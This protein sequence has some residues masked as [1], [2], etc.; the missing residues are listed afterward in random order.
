MDYAREQTDVRSL[1]SAPLG[2]P[3]R[4]GWTPLAHTVCTLLLISLSAVPLQAQERVDRVRGVVFDSLANEVLANA[5]VV[6]SPGGATA[7][8]DSL[9]RFELISDVRVA[10]LTVYHEALDGMG[11]GAISVE[12]P[13]TAS[14]WQDVTVST[15][16]LNTIWP[17][18]CEGPPPRNARLG[19]VTGTARLTDNTTRVSGAKVIVQWKPTSSGPDELQ[20]LE[21]TTDSLGDY[22]LCGIEAFTEP[23]MAALSD[24]AQSGVI[25]MPLQVR[26]LRRVDLILAT[27]DSAR[28]PEVSTVRG[29][30]VNAQG[31]PVSEVRVSIDGRE[32]EV[33]S[34]DDGTFTLTDVPLGTRMLAV[35]AVGYSPVSQPVNVLSAPMTPL[36]I[37]LARAVELEGVRITER[38]IVRRERSEFDFRRRAGFGQ[39]VDSTAIARAPN[40]RAAIQMTHGVRI[41]AWVPEG[42]NVPTSGFDIRGRNGCRA[43]IWLDGTPSTIDEVNAVPQ[44]NIAA[45]EFYSSVAF[46]PVR[47]IN[48]RAD[49]CAV[50]IVWTKN[51]L[52]P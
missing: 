22:V 18:V 25:A 40:V 1:G 39:F 51:G 45:I 46:A 24:R 12:R 43:H 4:E 11:L 48:V 2:T 37:S 38:A 52:R 44:A 7:T 10:Q 6:A 42:S 23:I 14:V 30:M 49:V 28:A 35:R 29:R 5:F 20:S 26:P 31:A 50:A 8:S 33:L 13:V 21:A 32:G 34:G 36:R 17:R 3:V 9:G 16:S 41:T 19:I 15:P 47:S 27:I